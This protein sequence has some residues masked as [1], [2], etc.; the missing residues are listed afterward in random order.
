MRVIVCNLLTWVSV[1]VRL[2]E[3]EDHEKDDRR[4]GWWTN[5]TEQIE[6][7]WRIRCK[8]DYDKEEDGEESASIIPKIWKLQYWNEDNR[9]T[10]Y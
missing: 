6:Q 10:Y 1:I 2:M 8:V 7:S 5:Y 9:N 3:Q 4:W